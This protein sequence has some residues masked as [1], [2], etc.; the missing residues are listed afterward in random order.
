MKSVL[1]LF[2]SS[3]GF[4]IFRLYCGHPI[5]Q[6]STISMS[7]YLHHHVNILPKD[8]YIIYIQYYL[9]IIYILYLHTQAN[10]EQDHLRAVYTS[11]MQG[12]ARLLKP[13]TVQYRI[14]QYSTVQYS[15]VQYRIEQYSTVQCTPASCR[16]WPGSSN[17]V[18]LLSQYRCLRSKPV[19]P[20]VVCKFVSSKVKSI[21]N[22]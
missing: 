19:S 2:Q 8:I 12:V 21:E 15:T 18:T 5:H 1:V 3:A 7:I 6:Q 14:E 11:I 9:Y 17:Q 13:G 4:A 16:G 20:N 10:Q 22:Q